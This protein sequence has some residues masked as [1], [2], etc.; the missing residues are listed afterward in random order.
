MKVI[1]LIADGWGFAKPGKGNYISQANTPIMNRFLREYPNCLNQA[2]GNAVGLP[3]GSQGN[4]E[5]GHLHM[6]AG[7]IVWQMYEKINRAI[8]DKSFYK[9]KRLLS[10]IDHAKKN[11]SKLHLMGLCSDEGVH[12]HTDHLKALIKMAKEKKVETYVH[13]FADGRDV[14]E[15]SAEKYIGMIERAGGKIASIVGRFYSMDRDNNWDRTKK[16]YDLLTLGSGF[17]AK[18]AK[19]AVKMAYERGDQTDYYIQPTSIVKNGNPVALVEDK[20]AVIFFNYRTDRPR[21]LSHAF[22]DKKFNKFKRKVAPKIKLITMTAYDHNFENIGAFEEEDIKND[23]GEVLGKKGIKQLRLAETEKYAHVTYFFNGQDEK[24]NKG[25]KRILIPSPKV[26]SYDLKPEM[27]AYD[28]AL[29]AQKQISS[30]KFDFI[31]INFA[32][33]DLVGHSAKRHAIIKCVEV[34]DRCL[35]IVVNAALQNNYATIVTADHGS[36]ED[37]LYPDGK[38]KPSHSTNPVHF[39]LISEEKFKLKKKGGQQDVAPTIMELMEIKQPKEM[40]GK[41]LIKK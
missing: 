2:S 4:S 34:V 25:E 13:F 33:C 9:N 7:R 17:Q 29:E 5:V 31:V 28:I 26:P 1:L 22:F 32:N 18:S 38:P 15:K 35:G 41:S 20:D 12:A 14:A 10:A 37:K 6:G 27:S 24:P 3:K 8:K 11:K 40:S 36:A 19:E 21:Q 16:A 23:L 30:N 39:I